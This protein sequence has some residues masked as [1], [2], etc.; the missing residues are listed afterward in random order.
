MGKGRGRQKLCCDIVKLIKIAFRSSPK[1]S[2]FRKNTKNKEPRPFL[3]RLSGDGWPPVT[4]QSEEKGPGLLVFRIFAEKG[5]L[6]GRAERYL[7]KLDYIATKFLP[8]PSFS[9]FLELGQGIIGRHR[10]ILS[11]SKS[12]SGGLWGRS[13][14]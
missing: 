6:G 11:S 2:L 3:L 13:Y 1:T 12:Q 8:S 7:D 4:T 5:G 10:P 14:V 9:H